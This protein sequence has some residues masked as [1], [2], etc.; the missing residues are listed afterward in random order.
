MGEGLKDP[1]TV[2]DKHKVGVGLTEGGLVLVGKREM[3]L[4]LV[5]V[6]NE[7][8]VR[9]R[10]GGRDGGLVV[11]GVLLWEIDPDKVREAVGAVVEEGG[12]V[13]VGQNVTVAEK[14]GD[15]LPDDEPVGLHVGGTTIPVVE[16]ALQP[17]GMGVESPGV[18]Q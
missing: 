13:E 15:K 12:K 17:Q 2:E 18:G 9:E 8:T 3:E 10:V 11:E 7:E 16:H 4:R 6:G 1:D 14:V 5:R